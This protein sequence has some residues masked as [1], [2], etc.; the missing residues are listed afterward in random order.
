MTRRACLALFAAL[1]ALAAGAQ[2]LPA[3]RAPI[4]E[5]SLLPPSKTVLDFGEWYE[6]SSVW[7]PFA[8]SLTWRTYEPITQATFLAWT[9]LDNAISYA[10]NFVFV[11]PNEAIGRAPCTTFLGP[12]SGTGD[13][14][15]GGVCQPAPA[16]SDGWI[17]FNLTCSAE[18]TVKSTPTPPENSGKTVTLAAGEHKGVCIRAEPDGDLILTTTGDWTIEAATPKAVRCYSLV[19]STEGFGTFAPFVFAEQWGLSVVTLTVADGAATATAKAFYPD[20]CMEA[21][22]TSVSVPLDDGLT[23]IPPATISPFQLNFGQWANAN[24]DNGP[25]TTYRAF[26]PKGFRRVLGDDEIRHILA[27]DAA[28]MV[29]RGYLTEADVHPAEDPHGA[30]TNAVQALSL[31]AAPSKA[32]A[33][34]H[35]HSPG[36][37]PQLPPFMLQEADDE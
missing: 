8:D 3:L 1:A 6:D 19:P 21:S 24:P 14:T 5:P 26:G 7:S 2:Q 29:R 30:V 11:A 12:E 4:P 25:V 31:R 16:G 17:A 15:W 18:T 28:E 13:K 33:K 20:G 36:P 27:R 34:G 22:E 35:T 23:A 10:P 32:T 9:R 37:A